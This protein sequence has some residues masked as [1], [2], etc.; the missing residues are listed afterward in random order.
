MNPWLAFITACLGKNQLARLSEEMNST[1]KFE[2][3]KM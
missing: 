2:R 1:N 3:R